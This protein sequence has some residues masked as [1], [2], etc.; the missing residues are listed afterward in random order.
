MAGLERPNR[1]LGS[2]RK[3]SKYFSC[4][5][6]AASPFLL[7]FGSDAQLSDEKHAAAATEMTA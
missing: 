1:I 6:V 7:S 2:Q 4:N 3:P 5:F